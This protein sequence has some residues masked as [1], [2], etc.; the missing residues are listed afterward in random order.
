[1][2]T[3]IIDCRYCH[4]A[5]NIQVCPKLAAKK[6][7]QEQQEQEKQ[8]SVAFAELAAKPNSWA[9]I[10]TKGMSE[11]VVQKI[12]KE[13]EEQKKR[14][15]EKAKRDAELRQQRQADEKERRKKMYITAME[16]QF[17]LSKYEAIGYESI[18]YITVGHFWYFRVEGKNQFD[19]EIAKQ[20]RE[21]TQNQFIFEKYLREKYFDDW[22]SE[23]EH[24]EDDCD[25]LYRLRM[26][27]E[28]RQFD[29][30]QA[31]E[32]KTRR[33][34]EETQ[35]ERTEMAQKLKSGQITRQE[36]NDWKYECEMED[37]YA[38][39]SSSF[40]WYNHSIIDGRRKAE[41]KARKTAREAAVKEAKEADE[42]K[43]RIVKRR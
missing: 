42:L 8:V 36:Y 15:E 11:A 31:E 43:Q 30:E 29:R 9:S 25:F 39:E 12:N 13:H 34:M 40:D 18:D 10:A 1:M 14:D 41:W 4:G 27:E 5:H 17:G 2:S 20:L 35:K 33:F 3:Q 7:F 38:M 22:L 23:S 16:K 21:D 32:E 28:Q 24:T 6:R 26:T 19:S 37:D